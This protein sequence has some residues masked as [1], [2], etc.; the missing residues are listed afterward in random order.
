MGRIVTESHCE[1]LY[2][3]YV[4]FTT[5]DINN[6]RHAKQILLL[7]MSTIVLEINLLIV[8]ADITA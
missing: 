3:F 6:N 7:Y 4:C 5:I 8:K 2:Y 1:I